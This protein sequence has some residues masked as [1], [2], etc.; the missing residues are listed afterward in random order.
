MFNR[1]GYISVMDS[2]LEIEGYAFENS[3][4]GTFNKEWYVKA[5]KWYMYLFEKFRS[6]IRYFLGEILL[7]LPTI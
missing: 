5:V 7:L 3:E 4:K 6:Y 2:F 1:E